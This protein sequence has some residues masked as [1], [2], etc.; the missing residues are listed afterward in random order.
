MCK[1]PVVQINKVPNDPHV[2]QLAKPIQDNTKEFKDYFVKVE[3]DA[4]SF[5]E[6][7]DPGKCTIVAQDMKA[8]IAL[9]QKTT[10]TCLSL[11]KNS[12]RWQSW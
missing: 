5:K 11:L 6:S 7:V 4:K 9:A 2:D 1:A 3:A 10:S 8:T 12:R